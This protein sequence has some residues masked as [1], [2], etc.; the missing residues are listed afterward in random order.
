VRTVS[1][2][3]SCLPK[4]NARVKRVNLDTYRPQRAR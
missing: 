1:A 2:R 3:P 4:R